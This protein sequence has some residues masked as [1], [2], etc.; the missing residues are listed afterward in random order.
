MWLK[1]DANEAVALLRPKGGWRFF[2][3]ALLGLLLCVGAVWLLFFVGLMHSAIQEWVAPGTVSGVRD[4]AVSLVVDTLIATAGLWLV[5]TRGASVWRSFLWLVWSE[6]RITLTREGVTRRWRLGP[7][8]SER[9]LTRADVLDVEPDGPKGALVAILPG[10]GQVELARAGTE[11]EHQALADQVRA[12]LGLAQDPAA[13]AALTPAGFES[14]AGPEGTWILK[15][16]RQVRRRKALRWGLLALFFGVGAGLLAGRLHVDGEDVWNHRVLW[17][18]AAL[19]AVAGA[20]AAWCWRVFSQWEVQKGAFV[21]ASLVALGLGRRRY[22]PARFSVVR[23]LDTTDRRGKRVL[24]HLWAVAPGRS[25]CLL[26]RP[27][28][29]R[30]P[31][32]L[33]L[34]LSRH[35]GVPLELEPPNLSGQP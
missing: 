2:I 32:H 5:T 22:S 27:H 17:G 3:A 10:G 13:I 19:A 25:R 26:T 6:E 23:E 8:R 1:L 31:L 33:G 15:T 9:H 11:A 28:V 4:S 29:P 34:W 30:A 20:R 14:E 7:W 16:S 12:F 24:F 35:A 21:D 18:L